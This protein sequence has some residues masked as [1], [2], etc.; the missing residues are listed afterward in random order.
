MKW[1]TSGSVWRV[2]FRTALA[3][4]IVA[5]IATCAYADQIPAGWES[6]NMTPI[7]Y[8]DLGGKE[9]FKM[10]IKH[11]GDRW[12]LYMGHFTA[13]GWSIVDVTDPKNP[14]VVK[15]I[16]GP[17]KTSAGQI[18]LH[19]NIMI[20]PLQDRAGYGGDPNKQV[21]EGLLVWDIHDPVNPKQL[22]WWKTGATGTHRDAYPGGKYVNMSAGMPGYKGQI[23]VFLDISEP[24]QP[25][26][27]GRWWMPGQKEGEPPLPAPIYGF[28]GPAV[29]EGDRA[30]LGYSPAVVIL[31]ISDISKP[32][33]IG[34]LT[35]SPPFGT[36]IPV[37]DV[38]P[39][40]GKS[41]L[42]THAEGTGGGDTPDGA[43]A[44]KGALFLTGLIDIKDPTK[45]KLV[46]TFPTPVPPKDAP[47]TDFCD[48][49]GRFG[50]H[51]TN[52]L[53]HNPDVEKQADLIYLTYFNAGLRIFDI[54][55]P[56]L[57]KETGWFIPPTPT[58]RRMPAPYDKL[59]SQTEDVLVDTRSNIYITNK[60]WGL[61]ILRYT[62]PGEPA[63]TAQ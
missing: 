27:A 54:K 63:P 46:S 45:P 37:H 11:V 33:L 56:R 43:L 4:G 32:K 14:Q 58:T 50:P 19:D 31:D 20:T 18:D 60:Q 61:F 41:L 6:S 47:Y 55:D 5:L 51:N 29:I 44:C 12:Y 35:V 42:F 13:H 59:V 52:I 7:G 10:A 38:M 23:L 21:N 22:S 39:I 49:G 25:K 24:N 2:L 26:E 9:A 34:Q 30:Y 62:G 40:P 1:R 15:F 57:P 48:K 8:S 16:P 28:H 3:L 36:N 53:Q 17:E